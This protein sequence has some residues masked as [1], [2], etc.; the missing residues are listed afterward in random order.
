MRCGELAGTHGVYKGRICHIRVYR[1]YARTGWDDLTDPAP[2]NYI[3]RASDAMHGTLGEDRWS[4]GSYPAVDPLELPPGFWKLMSSGEEHFVDAARKVQEF[5]QKYKRTSGYYRHSRNGAELLE[6]DKMTAYTVRAE[7]T[8]VSVSAVSRCRNFTGVPGKI[9]S[10]LE[11][12]K[13]V[14]A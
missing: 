9:R 4:R 10:I 12:V 2:P 14:S 11:N 13:W 3:L 1:P 6:E 5:L 8:E 7:D